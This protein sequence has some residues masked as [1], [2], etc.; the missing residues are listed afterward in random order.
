MRSVLKQRSWWVQ[1]TNPS[2]STVTE[3]EIVSEVSF[4][5]TAWKRQK[6]I[7]FLAQPSD[8]YVPSIA[9]NEVTS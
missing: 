9:N 5:W 3:E 8:A 1:Y 2:L 7:D 6:V 4:V